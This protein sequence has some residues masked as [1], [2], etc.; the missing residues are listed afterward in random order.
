MNTFATNLY[1]NFTCATAA[2]L[3]SLVAGLAFVQST[4]AAPGAHA[5]PTAVVSPQFALHA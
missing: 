5:A 1:R 4:S 2:A 3:I